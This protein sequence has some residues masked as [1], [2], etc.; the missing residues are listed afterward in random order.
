MKARL[1]ADEVY[2]PFSFNPYTTLF[3]FVS[4]VRAVPLDDNDELF[5]AA[6]LVLYTDTKY[7]RSRPALKSEV[8]FTSY[9]A[10]RVY[11]QRIR[12]GTIRARISAHETLWRSYRQR[13]VELNYPPFFASAKREHTEMLIL[14]KKLKHLERRLR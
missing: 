14:K 11:G 8:K 13:A 10:A 3:G 2:L 1:K 6:S 5:A 4:K 7:G 9:S 12:L